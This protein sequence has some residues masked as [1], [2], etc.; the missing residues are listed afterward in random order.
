[1]NK[2]FKGLLRKETRKRK[3]SNTDLGLLLFGHDAEKRPAHCRRLDAGHAFEALAAAIIVQHARQ[4]LDN[5]K[6]RVKHS[7]M[8]YMSVPSMLLMVR[9]AQHKGKKI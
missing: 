3:R 4:L 6:C 1:M 7:E 2:G 9:K 8:Q 5:A